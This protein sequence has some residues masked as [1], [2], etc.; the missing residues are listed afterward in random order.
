MPARN[1]NQWKADPPLK[2]GEWIDSRISADVD[3]YVK[4]GTGSI[5]IVLSPGMDEV[6]G[7]PE[8]AEEL[9]EIL[10]RELGLTGSVE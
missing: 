4:S 7:R 5:P 2:T 3:A 9:F 1:H 6:V 10:E 8:S